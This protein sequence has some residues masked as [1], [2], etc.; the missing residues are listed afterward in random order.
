MIRSRYIDCCYGN[1]SKLGC[2][3]G[4]PAIARQFLLRFVDD[5][6]GTFAP[7]AVWAVELLYH[8]AVKDG[9]RVHPKPD[10]VDVLFSG[11]EYRD[12]RFRRVTYVS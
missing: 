2:S 3:N 10:E 9:K 7:S 1:A 5:H 6:V 11:D 8:F 12:L 4:V